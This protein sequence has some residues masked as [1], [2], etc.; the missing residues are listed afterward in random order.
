M[1]AGSLQTRHLEKFMSTSRDDRT[2]LDCVS[3][4]KHS[5]TW[6][7]RAIANNEMRLPSKAEIFEGPTSSSWA[8][9]NDF[10]IRVAEF[11]DHFNPN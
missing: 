5:I 6:Y 11:D 10:A 3:I 7:E 2:N 8:S 4:G 1:I 9:H